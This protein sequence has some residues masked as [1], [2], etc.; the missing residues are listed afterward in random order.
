MG[1]RFR[2]WDGIE[3]GIRDMDYGMGYGIRIILGRVGSGL[4]RSGV[5]GGNRLCRR[6]G[7][8][9]AGRIATREIK[10]MQIQIQG[11]TDELSRFGCFAYGWWRCEW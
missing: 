10:Q 9:M 1:L 3:D 11:R 4:G 6:T 7:T 2:I 5:I 8:E